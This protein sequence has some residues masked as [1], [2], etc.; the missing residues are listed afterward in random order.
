MSSVYYPKKKK[1]NIVLP[2][3]PQK[4]LESWLQVMMW[5]HN[6]KVIQKYSIGIDK[7]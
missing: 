7:K 5:S 2:V 6:I 1:K 4:Q 3:H